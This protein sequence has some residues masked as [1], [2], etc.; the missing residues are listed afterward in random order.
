[1][2]QANTGSIAYENPPSPNEPLRRLRLSA[3]VA[4][5]AST[6]FVVAVAATDYL[7]PPM[8]GFSY[9]Y[10]VPILVVTWFVGRR[11][12][13]FFIALTLTLWTWAEFGEN[14]YGSA[15]T[16]G[17]INVITRA[18]ALFIAVL[19]LTALKNLSTR[20]GILVDERTAALRQMATRLAEA[21]DLERRRLATD[22]HDGLSQ[23][24]SLLKLNLSAALGDCPGNAPVATRI[25][26]AIGTVN[27]LIQK[28]R[29]L[30]FD[31]HPAMLEHLGLAPTLRQ[32]GEDFARQSNIEV[33]LNEEGA[34]RPL[35]LV[36]AQHL[37]RS[38]K[39]L[40]SN[41]ARHGNA[42]QIVISAHWMPDMLRLVVDDDGR[43]FDPTFA[44]APDARKG[45]G[46][47]S[48][49]E[50]MRSLGGSMRIE[51][52][53]K[54]GTRVVLEVPLAHKSL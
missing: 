10:A 19:L 51:S 13:V 8:F 29:T 40:M 28:S 12:G 14:T 23:V 24:L 38:L 44:M 43:G 25:Q 4:L 36:M 46:L 22:L 15:Y 7:T 2:E 34:H 39:E 50:R 49:N 47:P 21:E 3:V 48:I 45:L 27:E 41:A 53:P 17:V 31:L 20:L 52:N 32:Y 35:D 6:L 26:D 54:T 30:T 33:T 37:F 42:K 5:V 1:M 18:F 9:Y 11:A 16:V